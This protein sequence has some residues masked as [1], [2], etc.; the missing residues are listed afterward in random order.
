MGRHGFTGTDHNKPRALEDRARLKDAGV[1]RLN[2]S[3]DSLDAARIDIVRFMNA[4]G[5]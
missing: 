1:S 5:G 4:T 2:I 3:I